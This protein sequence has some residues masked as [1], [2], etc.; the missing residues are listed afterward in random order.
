MTIDIVGKKLVKSITDQ[1][2]QNFKNTQVVQLKTGNHNRPEEKF[3]DFTYT[4]RVRKNPKAIKKRLKYSFN[5]YRQILDKY[6]YILGEIDK[7]GL[8][9]LPHTKAHIPNI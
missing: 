8:L 6:R 7:K 1:M 2:K 9:Q 5:I 4:H 3:G